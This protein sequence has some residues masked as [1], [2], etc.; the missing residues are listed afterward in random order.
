MGKRGRASPRV[1]GQVCPC[2]GFFRATLGQCDVGETAARYVFPQA[3]QRADSS[4]CSFYICCPIK[5]LAPTDA[6]DGLL[7]LERARFSIHTHGHLPVSHSESQGHPKSLVKR[8]TKVP[9]LP[10]LLAARAPCWSLKTQ[11]RSHSLD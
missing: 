10:A 2:R 6:L 5:N 3:Q 8:T 1:E 7:G 11:P 4:I 9:G